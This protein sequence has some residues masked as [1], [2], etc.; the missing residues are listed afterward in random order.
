MASSEL[1]FLK[2]VN[3]EVTEASELLKSRV[4]P[5]QASSPY[6]LMYKVV[7]ELVV[8]VYVELAFISAYVKRHIWSWMPPVLKL[9]SRNSCCS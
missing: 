6:L 2:D 3:H 5:V 4:I 8:L 9:T 1:L 7:V